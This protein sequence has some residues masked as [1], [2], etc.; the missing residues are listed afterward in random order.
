MSPRLFAASLALVAAPGLLAAPTARANDPTLA[1]CITANESAIKLRADHRLREARAQLLV[2][3]ALTCPAEVRAECE[4]RV[5]AVNAAIP[6]IVFQAKDAAGN[7]MSAVTVTM[8]G[9]P[10]AERLEGTAI[11]LD[12]GEH[13]FHFEAPGQPP[14]DKTFVLLEGAKDRQERIVFAPTAAPSSTANVAS[15]TTS[16]ATPA[17]GRGG[18]HAPSSGGSPLRTWGFAALGAG[19]AGLAAGA[20]FGGLAIASKNSADCD[21]NHYCSAGALSDARTQAT[22]S[23]VAFVAGGVLLAGGI[24]MVLLAPPSGPRVEAAAAV[25]ESGGGVVIGGRF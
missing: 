10:L 23:T 24:T 1:D 3:A 22:V 2:C 16:A 21:G 20:I 17:A 8:D 4:R 18:E 25:G 9:K 13:T 5:G 14:I 11:S 15:A 12:P 7:D 19:A 6:T